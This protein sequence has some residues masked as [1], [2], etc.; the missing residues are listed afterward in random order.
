MG[1]PEKKPLGQSIRELINPAL[2]DQR[3]PVIQNDRLDKAF[4]EIAESIEPALEHAFQHF[5]NAVARTAERSPDHKHP[6]IIDALT[7]TKG[8]EGNS[9]Y[10]PIIRL[11][12]PISTTFTAYT[13]DEVREM[14]GYIKLHEKARELDVALRIVGLTADEAKGSAVFALPPILMI[15]A[16]KSYEEGAAENSALY[17]NLPPQ[18]AAFDGRSSKSF[19]M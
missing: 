12:L 9:K 3:K 6:M 11:P 7:V 5:F 8:E 2:E 13:A 16:S 10:S 4:S 14:P 15:D 1:V 17:P 19:D 18:K